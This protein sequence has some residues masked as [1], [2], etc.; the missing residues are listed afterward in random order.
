[1]SVSDVLLEEVP[2]SKRGSQVIV[3]GKVQM[4]GFRNATAQKAQQ[5]GLTGHA[6][7]LENGDV[8]VHAFGDKTML[9][10]L[11]LWLR[12][13]PDSAQVNALEISTINVK[14]QTAFI[15]G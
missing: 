3:H 2:M 13:G 11:I 12:H 8:E 15:T 4:V 6:F 14:R 9:D 5:L 7:N 1:M 10:E